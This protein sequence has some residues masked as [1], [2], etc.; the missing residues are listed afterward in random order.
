MNAIVYERYGSPDVLAIKVIELPVPKGNEVLVKIHA[1]SINSWDW[2][3]VRGEPF[4]VRMWGLFK[5]QHKI[6][7]ADIAGK[8]EAVG[9]L[10]K[11]F[12]PG[13]EVFG[14]LCECGWGGFAEFTCAREDALAFIPQ[15]LTFEEAAALPQAGLMALQSLV[16]KE[17]VGPGKKV[18]INGAGG[19]VGTLVLLL[20]R[21][22]K[23]WVQ[24]LL[25]WIRNPN[26]NFYI[27]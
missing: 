14:D 4:V 15:R 20:S 23:R 11:K 16:D 22:P 19:G 27:P 2:D 18:L 10:V 9:K 7:G 13:D 12:K 26:W 5:P 25:W 21:S 1:A 24:K 8:V 17:Q 3:M 6:P